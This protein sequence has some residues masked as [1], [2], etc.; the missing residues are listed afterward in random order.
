MV[1]SKLI[2]HVDPSTDIET[3][4]KDPINYMIYQRE[5]GII[6]KHLVEC[7]KIPEAESRIIIFNNDDFGKVNY[8][9]VQVDSKYYKVNFENKC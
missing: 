2:L 5:A 8:P 6:I 4:F 1:E 9:F 3:I 7:N